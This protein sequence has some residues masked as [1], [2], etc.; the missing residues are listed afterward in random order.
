MHVRY[1]FRLHMLIRIKHCMIYPTLN[2]LSTGKGVA[3][4]FAQSDPIL[5]LSHPMH[6]N[7]FNNK[8]QSDNQPQWSIAYEHKST[9][10]SSLVKD[11]GGFVQPTGRHDFR[12]NARE[13]RDRVFT[14]FLV[15][16]RILNWRRRI[17]LC[18]FA[19]VY[20]EELY[21]SRVFI[22]VAL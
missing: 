21:D 19:D 13:I 22:K 18:W 15:A 7:V 10:S 9:D 5:S 11:P 6:T 20:F 12:D 1:I 2:R 17:R 8:E 14:W 16:C 4:D 3:I